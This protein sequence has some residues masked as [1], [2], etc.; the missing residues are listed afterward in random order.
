MKLT[1][2]INPCCGALCI[3]TVEEDAVYDLGEKRFVI[4]R[5]IHQRGESNAITQCLEDIGTGERIDVLW[6][7][8]WAGVSHGSIQRV[9]AMEALGAASRRD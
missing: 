8:F 7:V 2:S 1:T 9:T 5:G 4:A 3:P 6:V